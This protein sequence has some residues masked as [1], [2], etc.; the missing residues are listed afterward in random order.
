M[1]RGDL[2][3]SA[4]QEVGV[5]KR[6]CRSSR[7]AVIAGVCGGLGEYLGFDPVL[8]RLAFIF[9]AVFN[10]FGVVLYLVLWLVL[11]KEERVGQP[12]EVVIRD[13]ISDLRAK[14]E[15]LGDEIRATVD[16]VRAGAVS[17]EDAGHDARRRGALVAS[18][19][20]IG[21]GV[22]VLLRNV[23][24]FRWLHLGDL[25]PLLIVGPGVYLLVKA[26]RER[27]R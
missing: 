11:P 3:R 23:G 14:A 1:L 16:G 12:P 22:L 20:L 18:Y 17:E 7:D 15:Q 10:G 8:V 13:N 24:V 21:A 25:W 19:L 6:L 27:S 26:L 5:K 4:C 2:G 9:F